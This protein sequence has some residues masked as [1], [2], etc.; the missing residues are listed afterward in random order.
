MSRNYRSPRE[1]IRERAVTNVDARHGYTM[2]FAP[3]PAV[4]RAEYAEEEARITSQ[5]GDDPGLA[6]CE[7]DPRDH[8]LGGG[9]KICFACWA[10][11]IVGG[12]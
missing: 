1:R 8:Y 9:I 4:H 3:S 6:I 7:H 12:L 10:K 11:L 2:E 5:I